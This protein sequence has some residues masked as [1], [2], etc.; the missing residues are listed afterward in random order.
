VLVTKIINKMKK[1][2]LLSFTLLLFY[3]SAFSQ[4]SSDSITI[5]KVRRGYQFLQH[6]VP[7]NS[8]LLGITLKENTEAYKVY[9]KSRVSYSFAMI[10]SGT[11]GFLIGWPLGTAIGGGDPNWALAGIGAGLVIIGLPLAF[12]ADKLL[13]SSVKIYNS[14]FRHSYNPDR[15]VDL[16]FGL[17][18]NGVG[19]TVRF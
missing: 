14:S 19:L 10:F 4:V 3:S 13:I 1:I 16:L 9:K 17:Q 2:I 12:N 15:K 8:A 11:G 6:G 18:P 5:N 7:L